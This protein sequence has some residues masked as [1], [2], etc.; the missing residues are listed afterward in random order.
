MLINPFTG[1][2]MHS[3]SE[4]SLGGHLSAHETCT[5]SGDDEPMD[6]LVMYSL[7]TTL[8]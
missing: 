2:A 8:D 4:E 5:M 3:A 1:C 7:Q 6:K